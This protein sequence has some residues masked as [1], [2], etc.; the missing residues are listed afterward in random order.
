MKKQ[1]NYDFQESDM[2][3]KVKMQKEACDEWQGEQENK[4]SGTPADLLSKQRVWEARLVF[5][6]FALMIG[7]GI[8]SLMSEREKVSS[9]AL[10]NQKVSELKD[11]FQI[12]SLILSADNAGRIEDLSRFEVENLNDAALSPDGRIL[13]IASLGG[14]QVYDLAN[15]KEEYVIQTQHAQGSV[16]VSPDEA[17]LVSGSADGIIRLW[18]ASNGELLRTLKGHTNWVMSVAF[19]SNGIFLVMGS[20]DGT[21]RLWGVKS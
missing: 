8:A 20:T 11:D 3:T 13:M 6:F 14:L 18:R 17:L 21:I 4:K 2:Y 12:S 9:L 1:V 16:L 10:I 7:Y 15:S 5:V 19:S